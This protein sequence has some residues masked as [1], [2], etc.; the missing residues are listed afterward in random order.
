MIRVEV[1]CADVPLDDRREENRILIVSGNGRAG[2]P[3]DGH[4]ARQEL[5][6][7]LH[8]MIEG[9]QRRQISLPKSD[10]CDQIAI[11][12]APLILV[13]LGPF[14]YVARGWWSAAG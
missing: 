6:P 9:R 2:R 11:H 5:I 10:P 1:D 12:Q 4:A 8:L 13:H 3:G 7:V 14:E